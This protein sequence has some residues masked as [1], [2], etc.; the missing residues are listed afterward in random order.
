MLAKDQMIDMRS[1]EGGV[2]FILNLLRREII[3]HFS[4]AM[5]KNNDQVSYGSTSG[6]EVSSSP[7]SENNV[8]HYKIQIPLQQLHAVWE[9]YLGNNRQALVLPLDAPPVVFR[10]LHNVDATHEAGGKHWNER[11]AWARQTDIMTN[12][13]DL[14]HESIRLRKDG[15]ILDIGTQ[16]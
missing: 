13:R 14:K 2:S 10:Q 12:T 11:R 16:T 9:V 1:I 4:M 8:N 5:P 6:S 3:I 7:A 15:S